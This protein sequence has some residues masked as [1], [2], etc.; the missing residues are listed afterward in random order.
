MITMRTTIAALALTVIPGLALAAD[1]APAA[2]TAKPVTTQA[3]PAVQQPAKDAEVKGEMNP[4][5]V[6]AKPK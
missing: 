5:A 2:G 6:P 3:A 1:A 4:A